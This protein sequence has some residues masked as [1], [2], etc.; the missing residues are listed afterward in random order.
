MD[1]STMKWIKVGTASASLLGA[2]GV[3]AQDFLKSTV[4]TASRYEQE[5]LDAPYAVSVIDAKYIDDKHLRTIPEALRYEP[6]VM[7]QKT[8]HGHGSP[9]IRGFTGRQNLLLVDGIRM[10]NSTWRSGPTQ[11]WNTLDAN[12]IERMELVR[13]PGSV[14]YGSDALGGTLN[15]LSKS[16]GYEEEK[17]FFQGGRLAYTFDTNSESHVGRLKQRVGVGGDWGVIV[18]LGAKRFGDIRDSNVGTMRHTGYPEQ[19][20]DIKYEKSLGEHLKMTLA[21]QYV[22]QDDVWRWHSTRYNPGWIHDNHVAAPGSIDYRIYDQERSLSYAKFEGENEAGLLEEWST[23]LSYQKSQDSEHHSAPRWSVADV[24]TFGLNFQAAG[25]AG[26]GRLTWGVDLYHDEV[27]SA[28]SDPSRRPV[29]DDASYSSY[30]GFAQYEMTLKERW[31]LDLG[32]RASHFKADWDKVWN[33]IDSVDESGSGNWSNLALSARLTYEMN[34]DWVVYGGISEGF[35]APNLDDLTGSTVARSNDQVIGSSSLD[36][37]K[38]ISYELGTK[39]DYGKVSGGLSA[40]YTRIQDP[41]TTMTETIMAVDYL[42]HTN[43]EEGY[44]YGLEG[45]LVWR[46]ADQWRL[47][48]QMTF[49]DGKSKSRDVVGGPVVEDTISRMAPISGSVELR[50]THPSDRFWVEGSIYGAATQDNLAASDAG[51]GERIP[52]NGTPGYVV[53]S[54]RSGWQVR[55]NLLLTCAVENLTD[56]DYRVHGSGLNEQ[57]INGVIG[58]EVTW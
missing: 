18:G 25:N 54:I 49:Q 43:G 53:A 11:Y 38:V 35:R 23:T 45:E 24:Q 51:D 27:D 10:N 19:N 8:T 17:G 31:N 47:R 2:N 12:G 50:W 20:L 9:F 46:F 5:Q 13:G 15:T 33:R 30:E 14:L 29:A 39:A 22:N 58:V 6:G 40:F 56:E 16:S 3:M 7:I 42:R 52:T 32:A 36:A 41:I 34:E 26:I 44:V 57:G 21:H 28:G 48:G 1:I 37:E 4:V 55:D